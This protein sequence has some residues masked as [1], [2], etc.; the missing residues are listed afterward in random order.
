M[1]AASNLKFHFSGGIPMTYQCEIK[2]QSAQPTLSIRTRAAVSQLTQ[3]LGQTYGAIMQYLGEL[4]EQPVGAPFVAYYNMDMQDLDMEIGFPVSKPLPDRG[5]IKS[6][7][8]PA[9]KVV[10]T[11]HIGPYDTVGPAYEALT[12]YAQ[13]NGYTPSGAAYEFYFSEP[14]TPPEQIQTQILFPVQPTA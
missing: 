3:L 4:G 9:G 6:G 10:V 2:D 8:L 14:E 11:M 5:E 12:H 7:A 13:A 1:G